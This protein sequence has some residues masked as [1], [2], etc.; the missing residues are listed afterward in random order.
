MFV[1]LR[2]SAQLL[3]TILPAN[4]LPSACSNTFC[5]VSVTS[6]TRRPTF[7]EEFLNHHRI[8]QSVQLLQNPGTLRLCVLILHPMEVVSK[9]AARP[10]WSGRLARPCLCTLGQRRGLFQLRNPSHLAVGPSCGP[11][12]NPS[13]RKKHLSAQS[14][15]RRYAPCKTSSSSAP[16]SSRPPLLHH[17]TRQ[18]WWHCWLCNRRTGRRQCSSTSLH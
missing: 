10:L 3:G 17:G 9:G 5:N 6:T 7:F 1:V 15:Q 11:P 13:R 14:P 8:Q 12:R 18:N 16:L 2:H 4:P